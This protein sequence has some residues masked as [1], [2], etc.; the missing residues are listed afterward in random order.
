MTPTDRK[1]EILY[2]RITQA[3]KEYFDKLVAKMFPEVERKH[4]EVMDILL[5]DLRVRGIATDETRKP[6]KGKGSKGA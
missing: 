6:S 1:T 5:T 2:V 3:N 4:S